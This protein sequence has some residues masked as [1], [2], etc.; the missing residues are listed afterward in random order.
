MPSNAVI[1]REEIFS[2]LEANWLRIVQMQKKTRLASLDIM[3]V[4]KEITSV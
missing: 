3:Q 4:E 2:H 1:L